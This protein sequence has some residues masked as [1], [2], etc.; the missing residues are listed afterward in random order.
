MII[1]LIFAYRCGIITAH[2]S[3]YI[4]F[5]K[6]IVMAFAMAAVVNFAYV[7]LSALPQIVA[8]GIAVLAGVIVYALLSLILRSE[9]MCGL[10]GGLKNRKK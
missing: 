4:D 7:K 10:I 1:N 8:F 6:S 3:D 2:A 9:A 5:A